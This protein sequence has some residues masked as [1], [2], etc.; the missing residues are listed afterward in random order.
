MLVNYNIPNLIN[1]VSQQSPTMR[2][3]SQC[4]AMENCLPS[5]VEFL[6]R[7]PATNHIARLLTGNHSSAAVHLIDRD[8]TEKYVVLATN[9]GIKV[10]DL[11]GNAKTVTANASLS[12]LS[13]K[14]PD[15]DIKF[16][17]INDYTFVLNRTRTVARG[18][19]TAPAQRYD[20]MIFVKQASYATTYT[21]TAGS[22]TVTY[23][24]P[25]DDNE[26]AYT[27]SSSTIASNLRS[28]LVAAGFTV[29]M[30]KSTLVIRTTTPI[31]VT[32]SDSRSNTHIETISGTTQRF[33]NLPLVA[34]DGFVVE[35]TGDQSS[36][37][38][39]YY[40][41]FKANV[42]G[43]MNDGVWIET[44]KPGITLGVNATTMPHA[45]VRQAN[46]TFTWQT[47][48]W[49]TRTC[50]DEASAIDPSF[51][52]RK[53]NNMVFYANRI[54]F[55]SQ[56]NAVFSE[57]GQ[58]F[59][60]YPTTATAL[61]DSDPVDVAAS[62]TKVCDLHHAIP[63]DEGLLLFSDSTQF[64]MEHEG[65]LSTRNVSIRPVT[66]FESSINASPVSA[67]KNVFFA[68]RRGQYGVMR[69]YYIQPD[70]GVA[71]AI[72]I[73]SHAP[74]YLTGDIIRIGNSVNEDVVLTLSRGDQTNLAI[75]KYFWQGSEKL[76][77]AW[78]K[79]S[80]TGTILA[81]APLASALYLV[82]QYADGVYLERLHIEPGYRDTDAPFEYALDRKITEQECTAIAYD[83]S[84][85]STT[86]TLPYSFNITAPPHVV[87]RYSSGTVPGRV[88]TLLSCP[89]NTRLTLQGDLQNTPLYIGMPFMSRYQFSA[90]HMRMG[91]QSGG[92]KQ[93]VNAGRLQLRYFSVIYDKSGYFQVKVTPEYRDTYT[94]VFSGRV[95]HHGA[96][97]LGE[98]ALDSGEFR[99]P[100][101]SKADTTTIVIESDSFLP[102]Q[103]VN[104]YWEGYYHSRS[105]HIS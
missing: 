39:N 31:T 99:F 15:V 76:Q 1:G 55:L 41:K 58:Y 82:M 68:G 72:D 35:V 25:R 3:P 93:V 91:A 4:E 23:T 87:T 86:I 10:F 49:A 83:A 56:E 42:A 67:G 8:E 43:T 28:Q 63:F 54:G 61:I 18:T 77:S 73:T 19:A 104:A 50:G 78:G 24:T 45:L 29:S 2:L 26:G 34:W 62:H 30:A 11:E 6:R 88:I 27:L 48:S 79:W 36:S 17:T 9:G 96:N 13:T 103:L 53:I 5:V 90:Q 59:N 60:F 84:T 57:V 105:R 66:E 97:T 74:H 89:S 46:G 101:M 98:V 70:T 81:F 38:D 75:Y 47:L 94:S 7:R 37:F 44:V 65:G 21:V 51:V 14:T 16:L 102:F 80:F 95:L 69:E 40:V 52:G 32:S 12:Y 20:V 22:T 92:A 100:V 33:N 71:D 85:N 64:N